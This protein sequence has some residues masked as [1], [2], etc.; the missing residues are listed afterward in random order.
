MPTRPSLSTS[1]SWV[2]I[3]CLPIKE[4]IA[5]CR[6]PLDMRERLFDPCRRRP[7]EDVAGGE[8]TLERQM[9]RDVGAEERRKL[10]ELREAEG[11]QASMGDNRPGHHPPHQVMRIAKGH[12]LDREVVGELGGQ[13]VPLK[14]GLP[15]RKSTR[16][17]SSH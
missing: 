2:A 17:N 11:L 10:L 7:T 1:S 4:R 5:S 8:R 16:L 6:L 13:R 9:V 3:W 15:N 12:A 14:C